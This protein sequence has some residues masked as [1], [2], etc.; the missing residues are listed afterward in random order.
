MPLHLL[1]DLYFHDENGPCDL[2]VPYFHDGHDPCYLCGL[3]FHDENDPCDPFCHE[4]D[5]SSHERDLFFHDDLF[6]EEV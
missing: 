3:Y 6:W 5:L 4:H 1:D 2:Y